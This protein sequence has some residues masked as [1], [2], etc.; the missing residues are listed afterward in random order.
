MNAD[1][2][3]LR[4][5]VARLEG[6]ARRL[7]DVLGRP[8]DGRKGPEATLEALRD[9]AAAEAGRRPEGRGARVE[10]TCG[11]WVPGTGWEF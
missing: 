3:E 4:M 8:V 2:K 10:G 7:L 1:V 9:A 11:R 6:A 5:A